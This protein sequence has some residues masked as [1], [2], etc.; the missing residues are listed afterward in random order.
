MKINV[1]E[2]AADFNPDSLMP[3]IKKTVMC[4]K[5]TIM[6][7]QDNKQRHLTAVHH[8]HSFPFY[9][10]TKKKSILQKEPK[11]YKTFI[12]YIMLNS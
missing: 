4:V 2:T 8:K 5:F 6:I 10:L 3:A 9:P 12:I 7:I 1:T 11:K